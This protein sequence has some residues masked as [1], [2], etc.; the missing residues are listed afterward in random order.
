MSVSVSVA[1]G[2]DPRRVIE[3]L[4]GV[5]QATPLVASM[6]APLALFKGFGDSA[7]NFEL[8]A[9][10]DL[11]SF[12]QARSDLGVSVYAALQA[13]GIEIPFPQHEVRLRHV[14]PDGSP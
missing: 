2:S 11:E 14:S 5:A 4:H 9:W 6:P 13:A 10:S 1:Y 3:L 12:G 7:L 8:L